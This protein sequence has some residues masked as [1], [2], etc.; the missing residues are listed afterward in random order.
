M[1][2]VLKNVVFLQPQIERLSAIKRGALA[3]LARALA[4]HARGH[5]FDSVMLHKTKT[6]PDG[7]VFFVYLFT[8]LSG[9]LLPRPSGTP[10][11]RGKPTG[12]FAPASLCASPSERGLG[13]VKKLS[14]NSITFYSL[15]NNPTSNSFSIFSYLSIIYPYHLQTYRTHLSVT[16]SILFLSFSRKMRIAVYLNHQIQ[17]L[18]IKISN[19][20]QYRILSA[21][22]IAHVFCPQAFPHFHFSNLVTFSQITTKLLQ[23]WIIWQKVGAKS[24]TLWVDALA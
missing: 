22:R 2:G 19:V 14:P 3:Q 8:C 6:S 15:L 24:Q 9:F 20:V 18:A 1:F 17:L 7:E 16:L 4:W 12:C 10:F 23:P 13:G 21:K 5:R 11:Q